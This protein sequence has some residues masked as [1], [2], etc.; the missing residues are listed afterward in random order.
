MTKRQDA[1]DRLTPRHGGSDAGPARPPRRGAL[2]LYPRAALSGSALDV[3]PKLLGN[4]IRC[5]DVAVRLTEV[6]AYEGS[7]DPGS[8]A[9][10]GPTPR[11]QIMFG[12]AGF[13]YVYFSYGMH[14]CLNVV[15]G[16]VG[17]ASAVLLRG[18]EVMDGL[19]VAR[20]RRNAGRSQQHRDRDL[21][22]GPA[23]LTSALGVDLR[24]KGVDLCDPTSLVRLETAAVVRNANVEIGP[25]VGVS[26]PGGDGTAYPWRFWLADE[27]TVSTYRAAKTRS[28]GSPPVH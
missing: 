5:G 8:H 9:Y 27:P 13:A 12:P 18:G 7:R 28:L 2:I 10:R 21:A 16:P 17:T 19:E 25:R 11:T 15:C 23:R 4:V 14:H 20:S 6:E 22:R 26:G 1:A 3:A 24:H